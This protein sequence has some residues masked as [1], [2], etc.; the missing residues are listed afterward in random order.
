VKGANIGGF[1]KV[2]QAMLDE[3]LVWEAMPNLN[4]GSLNK[5]KSILRL[6]LTERT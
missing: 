2:A 3:G 5:F 6:S 4:Q 1:V